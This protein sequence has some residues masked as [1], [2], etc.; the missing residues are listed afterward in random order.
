MKDSKKSLWQI[1]RE[2]RIELPKRKILNDKRSVAEGS[3]NNFRPCIDCLNFKH[4]V[5]AEKCLYAG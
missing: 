4:C 3:K 2:I 1:I 5:N